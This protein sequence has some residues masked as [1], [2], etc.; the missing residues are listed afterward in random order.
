MQ[1]AIRQIKDYILHLGYYAKALGK[2]LLV[3]AVVGALCGLL[4]SARMLLKRHTFMQV[5]AGWANGFLCV[6]LIMRLF[7]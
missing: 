4:G 7:G 5:V 2:W 3:A 6:S 1:S